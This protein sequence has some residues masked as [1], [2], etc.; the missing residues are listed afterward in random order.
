[1]YT[2]TISP[3]AATQ[4]GAALLVG[5]LLLLLASVITLL[6]LRV[7]AFEA[8]ST[9]NDIRAKLVNEVAEAGLAQGFEY[10][11][12]QQPALMEDDTAWVACGATEVA[13]PCGAVTAQTYDH[14]ADPATPAVSRRSTMYRLANSGHADAN[15]PDEMNGAMLTLPNKLTVAG[16][17]GFP[18]AYGVAPVLCY[19]ANR[20]L[21]ESASSPIRC[22]TGPDVASSRRIATFVSVAQMPGES[23]RTTLT[24]TVGR[25]AL[26]DNPIGK[27]PII[28]SGS[29]NVTGGLQV[30]TNPNGGGNGVPVSVWT[31]KNVDKTGTP[32]TCYADEFFRYGAKNNAPPTLLGNTIVCDTCQCTNDRT[33][34]F[35][36]SGNAIDEGMDILDVEGTSADRGVGTNYN[37]RSDALSYPVCEFPPDVFAH[38][39]GVAAWEDMDADCFAEKK[40]MAQFINPNTG[41]E[42]TIGADEA[43]LYANAAAIVNPT[44]A[45]LPLRAPEQVPSAA[46]PSSTLSGLIWCQS[47]CDIG[48]NTQLG[49]PTQPVIVVIDGTARIQG[50]VFGMVFIRSL[51]GGT[52]TPAAGYTMTSAEVA[53]GGGATLDMNAGAVVYGALVVHGKVDKAN[54]T[55]AVVFDGKVLGALGDNPNNNRYATLPGAWNDS[56]SY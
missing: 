26:V 39:F 15:F 23:A 44:A 33:L 10:L 51:T 34:S 35:D 16:A 38:I 11:M 13:F 36:K 21:G 14:D 43:F 30:V 56:V 17:V 3:K 53:T 54:G 19:V 41:V 47:N 42:V 8:R 45:G 4:R 49:T 22:T 40:V 52:L 6:A 55:A 31:R 18:V 46:Y 9:G 37:V 24:Q 32:N 28:S 20:K 27:P 29:V 1:M 48:S 12:R 50:R 25:F 5:V 7:G 2:M